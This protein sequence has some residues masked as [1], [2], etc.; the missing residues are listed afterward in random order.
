M[1]GGGVQR[2]RSTA[3]KRSTASSGMGWRGRLGSRIGFPN[4]MRTD[5]REDVGRT[6]PILR[7]VSDLS[8][9]LQEQFRVD[10]RRPRTS[11]L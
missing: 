10:G 4:T 3:T 1:S 5:Y 7:T 2:D 11:R 6:Q 9:C 8:G